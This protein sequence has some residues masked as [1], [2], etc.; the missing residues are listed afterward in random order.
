MSSKT[1]SGHLLQDGIGRGRHRRSRR[2][3]QRCRW[4]PVVSWTRIGAVKMGRSSW[5]QTQ[6][7]GRAWAW[8]WSECGP[9]RKRGA[10]SH[11]Q[12][13]GLSNWV[14]RCTLNGGTD[15]AEPGK[16]GARRGE[17]QF[18]FRPPWIQMLTGLSQ[19]AQRPRRQL[20]RQDWLQ[21]GGT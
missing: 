2:T 9:E 18:W 4:E 14:T 19:G 10:G 5:T 16:S 6:F 8:C 7:E 1:H 21:D 20:G 13:R 12:V 17:K 3:S 15:G 11:H